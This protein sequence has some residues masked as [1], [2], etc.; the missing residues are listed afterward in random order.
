MRPFNSVLPKVRIHSWGGLGSQL[1]T[2]H[3][4]L[5]LKKRFPERRIAVFVHT[6][7]VTQRFTEFDFIQ[8]GVKAI[9]INDFNPAGESKFKFYQNFSF[10]TLRQ[11]FLRKISYLL[12][13]LKI[14]GQCNSEADFKAVKPWTL[15]FRGH[16]TKI[17][18][19]SE[20]V[21]SLYKQLF[22]NL[23]LSNLKTSPVVVHYRLGDLLTLFEKSPIAPERVESLLQQRQF[24][25]RSIKVLSDSTVREYREFVTGNTLLSSIKIENLDPVRSM[26]QCIA[27]D[28]FIGTATKLSLWVAI[29]RDIVLNKRSYLPSELVWA[30]EIGLKADWY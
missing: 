30:K 24:D 20:S 16:Y 21:L 26:S 13:S 28:V 22:D 19:D 15:E 18:L 10:E 11:I 1:F 14:V 9:E 23:V 7:G 27:C 17:E 6:S 5:R 29:F 4:V 2:A 12:Q 8:I 25:T 3:L